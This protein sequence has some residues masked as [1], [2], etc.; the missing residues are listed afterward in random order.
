[1]NPSPNAHALTSVRLNMLHRREIL[2]NMIISC[3]LKRGAE[4]GVGSAPTTLW[5][6]DRFPELEWIGVDHFPAGFELIDGTKMPQERQDKYRANYAMLVEKFAP[7]LTWLD[8]PCPE[9]AAKVEDASLDIVFIDDDHSYEGCKASIEAWRPKVRKGGFLTGHD[10]SKE[11][12]PGVY[13]AVNELVPDFQ[14]LDDFV[15]VV[16]I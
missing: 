10:Y 7:R 4:L 3:K 5:L 9:A 6:L 8:L 14:L 16:Q 11:R 13:R 2:G 12:F 1:M 15:W